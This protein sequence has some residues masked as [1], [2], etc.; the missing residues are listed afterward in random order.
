MTSYVFLYNFC[1]PIK[2]WITFVIQYNILY[3]VQPSLLEASA[4][5]I[6]LVKAIL[7]KQE[8]QK[9]SLR[10]LRLQKKSGWVLSSFPFAPHS[11]KRAEM[12]RQSQQHFSED[13]TV[14]LH[15]TNSFSYKVQKTGMQFNLKWE[16]GVMSD[17]IRR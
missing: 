7:L 14:K 4:P 15:V 5:T 3:N 16:V 11:D 6:T 12:Q 17:G 8:L 2:H 1:Y 10:W 9:S 13:Q